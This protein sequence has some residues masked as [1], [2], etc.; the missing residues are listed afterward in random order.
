MTINQMIRVGK[1]SS[2]L[3]DCLVDVKKTSTKLLKVVM[4]LFYFFRVFF[5]FPLLHLFY[6]TILSL[7][8]VF[9]PSSLLSN[10]KKKFEVSV[11]RSVLL[12]M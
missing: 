1:V 5:F 10:K 7:S 3:W 6:S 11:C 4:A 2:H 12:A 8:V 9:F